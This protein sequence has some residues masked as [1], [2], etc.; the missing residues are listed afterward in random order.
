MRFLLITLLALASSFTFSSSLSIESQSQ[1]S[2]LLSTPDTDK[3]ALDKFQ[4]LQQTY[5]DNIAKLYESETKLVHA[6]IH[7]AKLYYTERKSELESD[8]LDDTTDDK[9]YLGGFKHIFNHT[10]ATLDEQV[11]SL[12]GKRLE[13]QAQSATL[14][15][16]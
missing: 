16:A 6:R 5:F 8:H 7:S 9:R 4:A 15:K 12:D 1:S 11:K 2:L 14:K 10:D 3:A 13:K